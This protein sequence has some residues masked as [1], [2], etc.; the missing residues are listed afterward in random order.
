MVF[1]DRTAK[2]AEDFRRGD[3]RQPIGRKKIN[4]TVDTT[5]SSTSWSTTEEINGTL[6]AFSYDTPAFSQTAT[7]TTLTLTD[8]DGLTWHT[9][10]INSSTLSLEI[11]QTDSAPR[12]FSYVG[13]MTFTATTGTAQTLASTTLTV[14]AYIE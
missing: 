12:E 10:T 3:E 14:I 11:L 8:E 2:D 6:K 7:T 1:G 9:K 13:T 4:I 5:T